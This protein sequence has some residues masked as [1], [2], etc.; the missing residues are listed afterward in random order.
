M[1]NLNSSSRVRSLLDG[2]EYSFRKTDG[3]YVFERSVSPESWVDITE[4][5][6]CRLLKSKKDFVPTGR[7]R[8]AIVYF[9]GNP[10]AFWATVWAD[11]FRECMRI[12]GNVVASA[13]AAYKNYMEKIA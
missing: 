10:A 8:Y 9:T 13:E 2:R 1:A 3:K 12:Y 5:R 7:P 11:S 6:D 4:Y